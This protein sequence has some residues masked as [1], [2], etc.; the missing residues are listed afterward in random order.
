MLRPL[1][2]PPLF[3]LGFLRKGIAHQKGLLGL[4]TADLKA[5]GVVPACK[6]VA[7]VHEVL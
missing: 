4:P 6:R 2:R 5:V 3:H 7:Q 1:S